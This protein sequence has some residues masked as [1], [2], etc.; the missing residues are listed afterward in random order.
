M[1]IGHVVLSVAL[2]AYCPT[3]YPAPNLYNTYW[4]AI[5]TAPSPVCV[6]YLWSN[7]FPPLHVVWVIYGAAI[8][9]TPPPSVEWV[10]YGE[11]I[12]PPPPSVEWVIYGAAIYPPS[13]PVELVIYGAAICPPFLLCGVSMEQPFTP[14]CGISHLR[15]RIW[16]KVGN[17]S[18]GFLGLEKL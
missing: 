8:Y 4:I 12:Y 14:L 13:P 10:I 16:Q 5:Y 18:L 11:A 6:G 1:V 17:F 7:H 15:L 2:K 9:P 3:I